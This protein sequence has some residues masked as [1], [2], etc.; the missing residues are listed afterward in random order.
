MGGTQFVMSKSVLQAE[1]RR[2][3]YVGGEVI[4]NKVEMTLRIPY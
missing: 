1:N 4:R 2:R 3:E